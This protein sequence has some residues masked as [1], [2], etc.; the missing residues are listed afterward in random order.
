MFVMVYN[1]G[2]INSKLCLTVHV[3]VRGSMYVSQSINVLLRSMRRAFQS[4]L[5]TSACTYIQSDVVMLGIS[6]IEDNRSLSAL[7]HVYI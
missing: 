4:T 3:F 1:I 7:V 5:Y 2:L 6:H